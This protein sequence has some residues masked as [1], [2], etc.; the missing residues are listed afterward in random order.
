[1]IRN[2]LRFTGAVCVLVSAAAAGCRTAT[3]DERMMEVDRLY[4]QGSYDQAAAVLHEE[5][6][7]E[8]GWTQ[9]LAQP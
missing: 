6:G 2:L 5:T 8:A 4:G 1:M 9:E 3:Y 7:G